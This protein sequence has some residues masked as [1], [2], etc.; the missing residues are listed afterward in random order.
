MFANRRS[1]IAPSSPNGG[2]RTPVVHFPR[3]DHADTGKDTN[4]DEGAQARI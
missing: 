4:S 1:S 3:R 2:E